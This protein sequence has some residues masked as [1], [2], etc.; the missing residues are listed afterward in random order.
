MLVAGPERCIQTRAPAFQKDT[1]LDLPLA[2]QSREQ[3]FYAIS[4]SAFQCS[5][6]TSDL[7]PQSSVSPN[8]NLLA[9]RLN[10]PEQPEDQDDDQN[11]SKETM[12]SVPKTITARRERAEQ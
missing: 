6:L 9:L 3:S 1:P 4:F 11:C 2:V 10:A 12:R 5:E 7:C 8:S